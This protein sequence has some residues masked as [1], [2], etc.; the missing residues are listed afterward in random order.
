MISL[1]LGGTVGIM[2]AEIFDYQYEAEVGGIFF[3]PTSLTPFVIGYVMGISVGVAILASLYPA[4]QAA[5]L[6][7]TEALRYE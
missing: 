7:P 3:A 5:R 2:L 1:A 6:E 4:W